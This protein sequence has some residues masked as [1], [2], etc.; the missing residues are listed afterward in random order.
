M[1][2]RAAPLARRRHPVAPPRRV[3]P[4]VSRPAEAPPPR[5]LFHCP[6]ALPRRLGDRRNLGQASR[7]VARALMSQ[8]R[9]DSHGACRLGWRPQCL[10]CHA[11]TGCVK[12]V[13]WRSGAQASTTQKQSAD[14]WHRLPLATRLVLPPPGPHA[15]ALPCTLS[16]CALLHAHTHDHHSDHC[17][18]HEAGCWLH[19]RCL[20]RDGRH[21]EC[22]H[23]KSFLA[24]QPLPP[25]TV[26]RCPAPVAV[27]CCRGSTACSCAAAWG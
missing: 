24:Q 2:P 7:A 3:L 20:E 17:H 26:C 18:T 15:P 8:A 5:V 27:C 19:R 25:C 6:G 14:S 9:P 16:A 21:M 10:P 23:V 4:R 1:P 22:L 12:R 11:A 13:G